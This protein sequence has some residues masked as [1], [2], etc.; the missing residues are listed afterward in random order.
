MHS[1]EAETGHLKLLVNG[2]KRLA[3]FGRNSDSWYSR[4][5]VWYYP[6]IHLEIHMG[7]FGH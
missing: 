7:P 1:N 6:S 2:H 4:V 3:P 5:M